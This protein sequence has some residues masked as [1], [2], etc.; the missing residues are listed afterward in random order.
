LKNNGCDETIMI[1]YEHM[2]KL[3][4]IFLLSCK[5][6]TE[7][8]E[9]REIISLSPTEKIQLKLHTSMCKACKSYEKQSDTIDKALSNWLKKDEKNEDMAL[10]RQ[11]KS[12]IINKLEEN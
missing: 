7:L 6:A 2:K 9:K 1:K 5:K 4:N 11:A 12:N 3:M 8:I 10:S